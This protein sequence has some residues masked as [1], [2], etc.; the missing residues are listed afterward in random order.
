MEKEKIA[1]INELEKIK[2][3]RPLTEEEQAEKKV[4]YKEYLDAFK[5]NMEAVLQGVIIQEPDGSQHPLEKKE[6][7]PC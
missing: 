6:D 3:L 2:K 4:L 7:K 1:I 5:Q